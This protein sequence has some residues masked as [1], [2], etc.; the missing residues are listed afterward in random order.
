[1]P[2]SQANL[3]DLLEPVPQ[4]P[5][6]AGFSGGCDSTALLH[7]L[8]AR[9]DVR[10]RGLR[11]IHVHHGLHSDA[12]SWAEHCRAFCRRI[13][14]ELSIRTVKVELDQGDGLEAS[15]RRAR[16]AAFADT[17]AA[18]ETLALAHHA[19]DQL[20]TVLLKLLRGAGPAGLGGMRRSR[21]FASGVLWRPLL[22]VA[23]QVLVDYTHQ[24]QLDCLED[25]ANA[26]PRHARSYLRHEILP[27]LARHWPDAARSIGH[28]AG[29]CR[30]AAD[31][32]DREVRGEL[33]RLAPQ[34]HHALPAAPWLALDS[35]IRPLV[36]EVWLRRQ[37]FS[38]PATTQRLELERQV[39]NA[40]ADR[41][42]C[43]A[44]QDAKIRLWRGKLHAEARNK[45]PPPDWQCRWN[46]T[47]VALPGGGS[48]RLDPA[49]APLDPPLTLRYRQGGER[50]RPAGMAHHRALRVLWQEL[51]LP[52]WQRARCPLIFRQDELLAV[53]DLCDSDA[54][55]ALFE[56]LGARPVWR[57]D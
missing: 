42:P 29:L 43:L 24:H 38:A 54:G 15:A 1:M 22:A 46:G 31:H 17:L 53:A 13:D 11:A 19:D 56:N 34:S 44:W 14:V 28:A 45:P 40:G 39:A 47:E 27:A 55:A 2:P 16:H 48:L 21:P 37:G 51:G 9:D 10:R 32:L 23:R 57:R 33:D 12:A 4:G 30:V 5:I 18:G 6:L 36:L 41:V 26:D 35:A 7:A 52:P 8:A 25:P 50:I 3:I 49:V 20:E